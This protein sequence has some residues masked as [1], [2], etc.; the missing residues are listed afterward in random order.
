MTEKS[1]DGLMQLVSQFG[2]ERCNEGHGLASRGEV[3]D[4]FRE[5]RAYAQSLAQ[6]VG[7]TGRPPE[8]LQDADRKLSIALSNTPGARLHAK[9]AA[10]AIEQQRLKAKP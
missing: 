8:M 9:E 7:A 1:I 6:P 10:A 3:N 4:L 2:N 5:I